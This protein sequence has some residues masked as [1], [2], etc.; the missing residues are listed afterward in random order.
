[1]FKKILMVT[2][3]LCSSSIFALNFQELDG[4]NPQLHKKISEIMLYKGCVNE[5][6]NANTK[7]SDDQIANGTKFY[8]EITYGLCIPS[9]T[10][11]DSAI[12]ILKKEDSW[13]FNNY[14]EV[15]NCVPSAK[16]CVSKIFSENNLAYDKFY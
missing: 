10:A 5:I 13:I 3:F 1:M 12:L 15:G 14:E 7:L 16:S 8:V 11:M 2:V 6:T 4:I 9:E